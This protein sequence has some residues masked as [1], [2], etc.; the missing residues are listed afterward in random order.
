[1]T[2]FI[3]TELLNGQKAQ[4]QFGQKVRSNEREYKNQIS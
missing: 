3:T 4:N 2:N 1:M